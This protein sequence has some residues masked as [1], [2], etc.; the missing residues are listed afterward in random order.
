MQNRPQLQRL[1]FIAERI[2]PFTPECNPRAR[3]WK[4]E[5]NLIGSR[6]INAFCMPGGK[7]AFYMGILATLQ[8]SD[9]EVATIMGHEAAQFGFDVGVNGHESPS[10][11]QTALLSF[12][13]RLTSQTRLSL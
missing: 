7:I 6:Q 12:L 13:D 1:R 5:V 11:S 8:L 3:D 2:I 10:T 9:D 4:W